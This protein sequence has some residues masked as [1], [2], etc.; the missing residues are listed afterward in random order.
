MQRRARAGSIRRGFTLIELLVV[1]AI[2][3]VLISLLLPA[4][5]Q[6]REAARRTQCKN[7]LKQIGLACHNFESTFGRLPIGQLGQWAEGPTASPYSDKQW[8]GP[9]VQLLPYIELGA[10]YDRLDPIEREQEER[11][12]PSKDYTDSIFSTNDSA[13]NMAFARI[14]G[15]VCPDSDPYGPNVKTIDGIPVVFNYYN[16]TSSDPRYFN[17]QT[18]PWMNDLGRTTYLPVGG[19]IFEASG[20]DFYTSEYERDKGVFR[21]RKATRF[22]QIIDGLSNTFFFGENQ[23]GIRNK[24]AGLSFTWSW[25]G[26]AIGYTYTAPGPMTGPLSEVQCGVFNSAHPGGSIHFLMGDGAVRA[27]NKSI[28]RNAYRYLSAMADGLVIGDF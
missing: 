19:Y 25:M 6:A 9:L 4:V 20:S 1:I 10:I 8:T 26:P 16:G 11:Q 13:W 17:L 24:A 7:N 18:Y 14:P 28:D 22:G 3:A 27:I 23:G 15:F 12:D 2:I 21:R 5:Q